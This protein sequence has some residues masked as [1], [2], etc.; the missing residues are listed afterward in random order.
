VTG[1]YTIVDWSF[2]EYYKSKE[3][4]VYA[5]AEVLNKEFRELVKVGAN[6]IQI[7]EPAIPTHPD[8]IEVAKN[9]VETMVKGVNAYFGIHMCYGNYEA[10]FPDILDFNV[11]QIDFEFAN[12]RFEDLRLL[13]EYGYD[14]DLGFGC[15]DVH[16]R[17]IETVDEVK[18][19]IY[20]ALDVVEPKRLY[21][22]PDCG[23]K[24]LPRDVAFEKLKV[25]VR[26]VNEV[27]EEIGE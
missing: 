21:V 11:D 9:A 4:A 23:M 26:A 20:M 25:M 1:A 8:E 27:R 7:D 3:E 17:R 6:Y 15:I 2:N 18:K 12:R 16:S 14:K 24:L 19:A 13:K 10:I 5:L 22:D